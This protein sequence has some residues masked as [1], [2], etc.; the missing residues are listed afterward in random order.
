MQAH[1]MGHIG[2][3]TVGKLEII[4]DCRAQRAHHI[5]AIRHKAV[6]A[7]IYNHFITCL[8][9]YA[10]G[11][12]GQQKRTPVDLAV[13]RFNVH[14]ITYDIAVKYLERVY[15]VERIS[16]IEINIAHSL[17][18]TGHLATGLLF[19]TCSHIVGLCSRHLFILVKINDTVGVQAGEGI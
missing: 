9:H 6:R 18:Y 16:G 11:R 12:E 19:R 1:D 8:I 4:A 5:I 10:L 3:D 7:D 15:R 13:R 14:F 17:I 2:I